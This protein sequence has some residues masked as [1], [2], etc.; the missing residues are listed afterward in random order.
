MLQMLADE[1]IAM[2]AVIIVGTIIGGALL[3]ILGIWNRGVR[4]AMDGLAA[5]AY[6]G[7]FSVT[8]HSVLRTLLDDTVFM[9]Q[10]HEVLLSPILLL[11]GVYLGPYVLS[12]LLGRML[13]K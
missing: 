7:F 5:L 2:T 1:V 4:R 9:T 6:A 13:R 8:A 3:Y 12:L 11:C 10:I